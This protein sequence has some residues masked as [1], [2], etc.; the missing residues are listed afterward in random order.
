MIAA[1]TPDIHAFETIIT[2]FGLL[3]NDCYNLAE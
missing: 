2:S 1:E 3:K